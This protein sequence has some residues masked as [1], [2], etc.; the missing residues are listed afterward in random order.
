[1][2]LLVI[3]LVQLSISVQ[4]AYFSGD[5]GILGYARPHKSLSRK[6]DCWWSMDALSPL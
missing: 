6:G 2:A 1:M 5:Y 4:P 3:L